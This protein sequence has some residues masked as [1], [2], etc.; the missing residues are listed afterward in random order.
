MREGEATTRL[1]FSVLVSICLAGLARAGVRDEVK[2]LAG[3][4][5][6]LR[7]AVNRARCGDFHSIKWYKENRR[8]FVYS[9]VVDFSKAEGELLERSSLALDTQEA[10]LT[11]DPILTTD[12]G[13]YKCEITFLD[14]SKNCPV[15][16]L[17]KLTTLAE[18][19][20]ANISL[21]RGQGSR[22]VMADSVV[23][24]FNEG[25][26]VLLVC[27]SG[28]GKPIP[29]VSWYINGQQVPGRAS[30]SEDADRTG[31][32]RSELALTVGRKQL[33]AQLECKADNEAV[34]SPLISAIQLDVSLRPQAVKIGGAEAAVE[35]GD[36][37]SLL[38]SASGARPA[39]VLTW[40]NGTSL[41]QEQ[42]A[43]QVSLQPDG[44]Y[45]TESR[46]SF[47]ATRFEDNGR[48]F[49]EGQ[50]DV[51]E[52]YKE[53]PKRADTRLQVLYS[54]VVEIRPL[55]ITVNTTDQVIIQCSYQ[56]NPSALHR[57]KW[58][59]NGQLLDTKRDPRY[60][61]GQ[62]NQPSLKIRSAAK[63][64]IGSY[65]CV[66]E[67][68]L[69][70]GKSSRSAYLDVHY[71]PQVRMRMEPAL[72]VSEVDK[73]NVTLYC[74][75]EEGNPPTLLA[76]R[77]FMDKDLLKQLP[78]CEGGEEDLCDIDPSKLL[79]EHVSRHFHGNFSCI[80]MNAAGPSPMSSPIELVVLY[81]PGNATLVR[82]RQEVV[83]GS[84]LTLSCL[85]PDLGRPKALLYK[86]TLGDHIVN[87]VTTE[88]WTVN[89]VTLETQANV[90]CAAVNHVGAGPS[91]STSIEVSAPPSFIQSLGPYTGFTATSVN[92]SLLCQVECSPLCDILW[93]KDG[94]PIQ[95]NSDYFTV[96]ARQVPPNYSKNDFE[97]VKS[98]LIW[99][100]ENWNRG[101]LDRLQDNTHYSCKSSG[102]P[103][104][105]GVSSD[106][107]F[108]VEYP[109]DNMHISKEIVSVVENKVPEKV[110]C[111]AEAYPEASFMWRFN[112]EVIQTQNLLNF[113]SAITREQAG[114]YMCEAQNRHGTSYI[115]TRIEVMYKPECSIQQEKVEDQILL[116][117][118]ADAN[119]SDVNY[120]WKK[121]NG[122]YEGEVSSD[123]LTSTITLGLMQES[124]GTYFCFVTNDIGL[125]VPCEID[126][127]GIGVARNISDTKVILIV[128]VIAAALVA[129]VIVITV[130]VICRRR[131]GPEKCPPPPQD[132]SHKEEAVTSL[133][134]GAQPVHKW[135]LRP[136]VHVHVNGLTTLTGSDNKINHQ[137]NGFSYGAKTSRSSSSSGSDWVSNT[138]SN[139]ELNS[140]ISD[141]K[142]RLGTHLEQP[143]E[144]PAPAPSSNAGSRPSSRQRKKREGRHNKGG[145]A[146]AL[147]PT[148]YENVASYQT[149]QTP[150]S[151]PVSQLSH[152]LHSSHAPFGSCRSSR[153]GSRP[154]ASP[155][156]KMDL[157]EAE[158]ESTGERERDMGELT[159]PVEAPIFSS[160]TQFQSLPRGQQHLASM[161]HHP[162][163]QSTYQQQE[164][165]GGRAYLRPVPPFPASTPPN[166][167]S[168]TPYS[169][170]PPSTLLS[171]PI[172]PPKQFDSSFLRHT[173]GVREEAY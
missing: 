72:P 45:K 154:S 8:V 166:P 40:Y 138:S 149:R 147:L 16:Q 108:R 89:P 130:V 78:Q 100:L 87:H 77:W 41:F 49:C 47:I 141:P 5:V 82:S 67:N 133:A 68:T 119:P 63:R 173:P 103:V 66:L 148:F 73:S 56:A 86:W 64:D 52:F 159:H 17:V 36:V 139:P 13:E 170:L 132:T 107:H 70:S 152:T 39:A 126:I 32:G 12:E 61:G 143:G 114:V 99:K 3:S 20:Y 80:G 106:T 122:S 162:G 128:A 93:L 167:Y 84:E 28:G 60:E 101:R 115:H 144:P 172:S 163:L 171:E 92:V 158:V 113:G 83:K 4:S 58:Y 75:L 55:N 90:S 46:L 136:G 2:A 151:R 142:R 161:R 54:P 153:T 33:G 146:D 10:R 22:P 69:G 21:S 145:A 88:T 118:R 157:A 104:G 109:P 110:L 140:D 65:S 79:L 137:I 125:G 131:G 150:T 51:L 160:L 134:T 105:E 120:H 18:P 121:G 117:C 98:E 124:F 155:G 165:P 6:S 24:P 156:P 48:V 29:Q 129:L 127:Q 26:E 7:C 59:H 31:T 95:D 168:S 44:T 94:V 97:S 111:T 76:V 9:P 81:P 62:L 11:I 85:V 50:N 38:C 135:P 42:P 102:N 164:G 74:D 116:T 71:P 53:E 43:G 30:S 112:D 96:R 23:G 1:L 169:H 35:A 91:D 37:V 27:E 15:V 14:I 34:P 25:T 57:V 19:K 123:G